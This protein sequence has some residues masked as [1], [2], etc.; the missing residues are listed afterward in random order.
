MKE[1]TRIQLESDLSHVESNLHNYKLHKHMMEL[2]MRK[3]NRKIKDHEERISKLKNLL[4][5]D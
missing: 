3:T 1:S 4:G 2:E 5:R